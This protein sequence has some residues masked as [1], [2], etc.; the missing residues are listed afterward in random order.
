MY[1]PLVVRMI[2]YGTHPGPLN[3]EEMKD[4]PPPFYYKVNT[5]HKQNG[6]K[7]FA[8]KV[9]QTIIDDALRQLF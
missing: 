5:C 6:L 8:H 1:S 7:G 2:V 3:L 4:T 9:C